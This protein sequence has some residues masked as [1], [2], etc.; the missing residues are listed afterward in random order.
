[1][2]T[3]RYR[4]VGGPIQKGSD[5]HQLDS[6]NWSIR[7]PNMLAPDGPQ[8]EEEEEAPGEGEGEGADREAPGEEEDR[9]EAEGWVVVGLV[10]PWLRWAF[11]G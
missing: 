3:K 10:A 9:K 8:E 5:Y 7:L 1:M 4:T 6:K 11:A 2:E